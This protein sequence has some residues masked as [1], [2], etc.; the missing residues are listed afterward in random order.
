[1]IR[2]ERNEQDN[3]KHNNRRMENTPES[4]R[5]IMERSQEVQYRRISKNTQIPGSDDRMNWKI[6]F[7]IVFF[8][9]L[10]N[11]EIH[12]TSIKQAQEIRESCL[13]YVADRCAYTPDRIIDYNNFLLNNSGN[14]TWNMQK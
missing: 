9:I 14:F 3:R 7:A 5:A 6:V 12:Q 10:I 2:V 4:R 1:M 11:Y 13:E 8:T